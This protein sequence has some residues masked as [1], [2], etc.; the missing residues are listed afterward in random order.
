MAVDGETLTPDDTGDVLEELLTA[1]NESYELGLKLGVPQYVVE[2]IHKTYPSQK[3][4]LLY[5]IIEFLKQRRPTWRVII[6][7]LRNPIVKLHTL[8]DRVEAAHLP[9]HAEPSTLSGEL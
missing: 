3:T 7:A 9:S 5:V 2:G 6:D 1:S 8:A 4:R